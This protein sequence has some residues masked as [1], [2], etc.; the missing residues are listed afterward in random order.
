M[1]VKRSSVAGAQ[2]N[3]AVTSASVVALTVPDAANIAQMYVRTAPVVFTRNGTD[4]TATKG[5]EAGVGDIIAL[6]SRDELDKFKVIAVSTSG[7]LDDIE[8]FTDLAG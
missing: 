7:E 6:N 1:G 4:P 2:F 5:M 8:F 3:L